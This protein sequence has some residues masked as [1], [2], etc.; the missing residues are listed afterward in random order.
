M[1][2]ITLI[3]L[4]ALMASTG[5]K[6]TH[7]PAFPAHLVDYYPYHIGDILKFTNPANDTIAVKINNVETSGKE[8]FAWN[9]KCACG[10]NHHYTAEGIGTS[11]FQI[12]GSIY[13][14]DNSISIWSKLADVY[15]FDN[16]YFTKE[17]INPHALENSHI[18]GD[19]VV[20]EYTE[21]VGFNKVFIVKGEGL[22]EFFDIKNNCIWKK[23]KE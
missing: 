15:N 14:S 16:L 21:A 18:F 12:G 8:S 3:I 2:N 9:C 22:V 23:V 10:F 11:K 13:G 20:L 1:K 5:C 6:D 7:C 17:N 4:T 19:T